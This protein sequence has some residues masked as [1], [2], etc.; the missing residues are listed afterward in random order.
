[1]NFDDPRRFGH[2]FVF[3]MKDGSLDSTFFSDCT[4]NFLDIDAMSLEDLKSLAVE[5]FHMRYPDYELLSV[6]RCS[7]GEHW[8]LNSMG[9]FS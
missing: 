5:I 7:L 4:S 2:R 6:S 3:R 9:S 1:M 8:K